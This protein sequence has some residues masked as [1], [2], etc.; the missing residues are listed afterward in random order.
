MVSTSSTI[1][2]LACDLKLLIFLDHLSILYFILILMFMLGYY[3]IVYNFSFLLSRSL[4]F[5][6]FVCLFVCLLSWSSHDILS[7]LYFS[8]FFLEADVLTLF[9]LI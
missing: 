7:D 8:I 4:W 5:H 3:V 9:K 6:D 2:P 1:Y